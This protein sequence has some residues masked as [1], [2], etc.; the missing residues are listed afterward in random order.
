MAED[1]GR[2]AERDAERAADEAEQ[3]AAQ[4]EDARDDAQRQAERAEDAVDLVAPPH[5]PVLDTGVRRIEA[6]VDEDNPYGRRGKPISRQSP[7]RIAFIAAWGVAAAALLI[8]GI[9]LARQVLILILVSAFLAVGLDPAVRW[10]VRRG[11]K[12]SLAVLVIVLAALGFF[13]GF[14]AAVA[15]PIAKQTTQLVKNTPDY[16]ERLTKNPTIK[17]LDNRYHF[18]AKVQKRAAQGININALGGLFGVGKAIL[19]FV[20]STFTVIILTIYFLANLTGIKRTMYRIVPRTRRARV[21]L[22]SDEILNRVGGYVLG[23]LATS[24]VAGL[25]TFIWLEAWGVPYPVALAMFVAITDLIPLIGATLGAIGV[26]LVAF[27]QGVPVGV[28]TLIYYLAYQQF[29]NY[30]L[31]PRVMKRTVDVAPVVTIVAA[32]LGAALLGVLGALIAV[33]IAAGVQLVLTEVLFPRQDQ[34]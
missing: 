31:Q 34:A 33:P 12:R 6:G 28:A 24:F 30:V 21:G 11:L 27:F 20:A 9:V 8:D 22:L 26:T 23:N 19:G 5:D 4:A 32:L 1:D 10:L 2:D 18:V 25:V 3:A 13:G 17:S 7:F 15:P 16:V 29:E 14:V